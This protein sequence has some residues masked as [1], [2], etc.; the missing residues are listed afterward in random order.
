MQPFEIHLSISLVIGVTV[1][2]GLYW[3]LPYLDQLTALYVQD[4]T[5]KLKAGYVS[6]KY[7]HI[8]LR[9][10][11]IA[12]VVTP[13]VLMVVLHQWL[14]G[15]FVT[16]LIFILPR[17]VGQRVINNQRIKMRDQLVRGCIN[18]ANCVRA[19]MTLQQ[20]L[21][22]ILPET[23][24]P[25]ASEFRRIVGEFK[26]GRPFQEAF[27]DSLNR[28]L[29]ESYKLFG[30]AILICLERGGKVTVA[31]DQISKNLLEN[32]R[33]ERKRE[34]DTASGQ[35]VV[36]ILAVTPA[37]FLALFSL[38]DPS[39]TSLIFTTILGQ[40]ILATVAVLDYFSVRWARSILQ[41]DAGA[42]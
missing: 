35:K 11:V 26:Q 36:G 5:P 2:L 29:L 22:G 19:G 38:L 24:E 12:L 6:T 33:L 27:R 17:G 15:M 10:W 7:L 14:L 21:E 34:A 37:A 4:L 40:I 30:N 8:Y 41:L 32:Q 18:L 42:R 25:L 3:L 28:L 13:V 16:Y 31:L 9:I 20:G 39:G 1:A 23:P